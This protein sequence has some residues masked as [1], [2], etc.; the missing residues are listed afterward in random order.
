M[1]QNLVLVEWLDATTRHDIALPLEEAIKEEPIKAKTVGWILY[2]DDKKAII[3]NFLFA[4]DS[5]FIETGY[6]TIHIIPSP[7]IIS[8]KR[9]KVV[10][11]K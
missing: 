9:L 11:R 4:S 2:K 5:S 7:S 6:K 1:K 8:I 3:C 10:K